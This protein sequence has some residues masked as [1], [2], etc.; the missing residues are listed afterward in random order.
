MKK[1]LLIAFFILGI[2]AGMLA[3]GQQPVFADAKSEVCSGVG[4][5][6][7]AGG[8]ATAK[9]DPTVESLVGSVVNILSWII[10]IVAVIM[11]IISGFTYVTS[12][13][14]SGKISNA[15]TTLIYAIVGLVVVAFSQVIVK[16][17]LTKV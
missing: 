16:F 3:F 9:G 2:S 15:K 12:G 7:G 4:A 11:I 14:D 13:G 1:I 5:V 10:G 17:V 6:S 8:C